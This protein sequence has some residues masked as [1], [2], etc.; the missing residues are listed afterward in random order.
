[1]RCQSAGSPPVF[2]PEDAGAPAYD[3][4]IPLLHEAAMPLSDIVPLRTSAKSVLQRTLR[5]RAAQ[6]VHSPDNGME[7]AP[8]N[9]IDLTFFLCTTSIL[10]KFI[11]ECNKKD[12]FLLILNAEIIYHQ[13]RNR[14]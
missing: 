2:A 5:H 13:L 8:L 7:E 14:P 6:A 4:I 11:Q 3:A 12:L 1:M 9:T 10:T